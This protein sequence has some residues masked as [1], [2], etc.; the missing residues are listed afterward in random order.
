MG[1]EQYEADKTRPVQLFQLSAQFGEYFQDLGH[2]F[3]D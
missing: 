2:A 1:P 3:S